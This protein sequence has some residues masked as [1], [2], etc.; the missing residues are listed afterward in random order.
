V[1]RNAPCRPKSMCLH[2]TKLLC[3]RC[4]DRQMTLIYDQIATGNAG[5]VQERS[6]CEMRPPRT[7]TTAVYMHNV[8]TRLSF[9]IRSS[10]DSC[11]ALKRTAVAVPVIL[12]RRY[13]D[14]RHMN[15]PAAGAQPYR[16]LELHIENVSTSYYTTQ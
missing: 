1:S 9:S 2:H 14:G 15:G 16:W 8:A 5:Y 12:R 7:P 4:V 3:R 11:S 10:L 6:L 13:S